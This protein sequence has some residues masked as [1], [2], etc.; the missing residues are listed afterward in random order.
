MDTLF[1][2]A[3]KLIWALLRPDSW[4]A[5]GLA[6]TV[7]GVVVG[8]RRLALWAGVLTLVFTL[9]VG[10]VPLGAILARPLE[11]RYPVAPELAQVD[12]IIILGGAELSAHAAAHGGRPQ[13]NDAGERFI[14]GGVLA[15]EWPEARVVFT[16][17]SGGLAGIGRMSGNAAMARAL[18]IEL[19]VAPERVELEPASRNTAENAA[20]SHML[21]DPQPGENWVLVTSAVH[22]P[23][24]MTSFSRAG[25]EG[26]T[27]WPADYRSTNHNGPIAWN[28]S[29]N[30]YQLEKTLKEYVGS[31]AYSLTGR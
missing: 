13:V 2:I 28:L 23:R 4:L 5:L 20:F 30:L 8:R 14:E 24:A 31:T 29:E 22:M 26:V 12:G 9:V 27:P 10:F 11:L 15:R 7:L 18:L 16:G 6:L 17:G 21:L 25:W 1:F 19:G 3:S